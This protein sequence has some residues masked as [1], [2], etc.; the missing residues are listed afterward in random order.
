M[1]RIFPRGKFR[2]NLRVLN[3]FVNPYIDRAL[4]LSP[5]ELEKKTRSDSGYTFLHAL[6]SFTRD[7]KVLRDQ[8]VAVLLAGRVSFVFF[9]PPFPLPFAA[10]PPIPTKDTTASTLSWTFYELAR[11]P[12][13]YRKLRQEILSHVGPDQAPTY[14]D[15]KSLKYLQHV[16][17]ETLRLYP[18]VPYNLRF[19]L[20]DTNLPHGGGPDGLSPVGVP[21]DTGILYSPLTMQRRPGL[22]PPSPPFPDPLEFCPERWVDWTPKSWTFIPFNGGPRICVGQ[23]FALTEMGY[24]IVRVLQRFERMDRRW[25]EDM[26]LS[27]K[28]EIVLQPAEEVRVGF[29]RAEK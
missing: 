20:E 17:N 6:A 2:R 25:P 5:E 24:T 15:L 19:A 4:L 9:S 16:M 23:Q 3:E 7:R 26:Q 14:T 10:N 18:V 21:K 1:H 8:I 12:N 28:S 27:L 29:W 22:Y 11:H 13:I